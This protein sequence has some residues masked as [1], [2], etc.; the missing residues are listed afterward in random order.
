[1]ID[2]VERP[3]DEAVVVRAV[4][5]DAVGAIVTFAGTVRDHH[6]GR[7]VLSLEY[8]A[9]APMARRMLERIGAEAGERWPAVRLAIV[10]RLGG[11]EI[12]ETSVFIAAASAHRAEAFDAC[13]YAIERIKVDVPIWKRESYEGGYV[14]VGEQTGP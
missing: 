9:Y 7:R 10:H 8:R 4:A 3:I 13:R 12:G 6:A 1:M 11:L 14:W 5:A 2:L